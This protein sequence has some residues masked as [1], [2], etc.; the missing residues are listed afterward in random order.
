MENSHPDPCMDLLSL[1]DQQRSASNADADA[2]GIPE[3][4]KAASEAYYN[5][6]PIMS[7]AEFDA[8]YDQ[9]VE[10]APEHPVLSVIGAKPSDK[11]PWQKVRHEVPMLSLNKAQS[12]EEMRDWWSDRSPTGVQPAV[13]MHKL[14]G[15][16]LD[17]MYEGGTLIRASTRG[18]GEVGEDITRNAKRMKGVPVRL[19]D[20][21]ACGAYFTS[22]TNTDP[23][24]FTGWIR[25][26]VL[27]THT[28][29]ENFPDASNVRNIASGVAKRLDGKGCEHLT[30]VVY[31]VH[32]PEGV[33]DFQSKMMELE[34]LDQMGFE[35]VGH[36]AVSSPDEVQS[37]WDRYTEADREALDYDIDGLVVAVNDRIAFNKSGLKNK[38]PAGAVAYKFA[39]EEKVTTL[40]SIEWQ[41]GGTGRITPVAVFDPVDLAG[42]EVK[43]ASLATA[44]RVEDLRLYEECQILVSRRNDVIP[45]VEMNV[46]E[47]IV[48][49]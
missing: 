9:L 21:P 15:I 35:V 7:D 2:L 39:H 19:D 31:A 18:N 16:A 24:A 37:L 17:L 4:L 12:E 47:G 40:R 48:N 25:G 33:P 13:V 32:T 5:G 28:D 6:E 10:I 41:V 27:C 45:R 3:R 20:V 49:E 29:F 22:G 43:R 1:H 42:A 38:R 8:L 23:F 36:E 11:S 34:F 46:S 14:D 26:E 30:V 44:N